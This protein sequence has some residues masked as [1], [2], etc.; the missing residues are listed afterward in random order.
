MI[1]LARVIGVFSGKGGVGKTTLVA[2]LGVALTSVFHKNVVVF[3]SNIHTS[4][5]GLH[6][7]LYE[8]LPVTLREVVKKKI[9]IAQAVYIHPS[10][11]LRIIPAPLNF[12]GFTLTKDKCKDLV[13][14]VKSNYD[15]VLLDC[16]PGL[17]SEV[18]AP[19]YAIDEAIVVSTSDL[20]SLVDALKTIEILK[21][22]KKNVLGVVINRYKGQK[23]ELTPGE[24]ASTTGYNVLSVVSE[25][26]RVPESISKGSPIVASYP[27]S[28][29]SRSFKKL[30]AFLLNLPYEEESLW[31]RLFGV[32]KQKKTQQPAQLSAPLQQQYMRSEA[33][34]LTNVK[35]DLMKEIK[36]E[37]KK[38]IKEKVRKRLQEKLNE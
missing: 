33:Q 15:V 1:S 18:M 19:M 17:G 23:Y 30:A 31:T 21:K 35:D 2:N 4:H 28:S 24:V 26:S 7:G 5:I 36:A 13:D 11:G 27:S 8:D 29:S 34:D 38:E 14:K 25:D 9:P 6:F 37:L 3:D 22:M 12:D 32:F 20:A 16:A 10:T